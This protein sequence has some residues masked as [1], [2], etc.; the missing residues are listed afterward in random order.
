MQYHFNAEVMSLV[1]GD[2]TKIQFLTE[3]AHEVPSETRPGP[4][5]AGKTVLWCWRL[6]WFRVEG[7]C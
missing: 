3:S 7:L 2:K 1:C 5:A 6:D 4:T